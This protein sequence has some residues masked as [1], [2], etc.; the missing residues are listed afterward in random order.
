VGAWTA[1]GKDSAANVQL[2]TEITAYAI[3]DTS[4]SED[5][6]W[7][8]GT[9]VAGTF[10]DRFFIGAGAWVGSPT[11]T[12][13]GTGTFNA[14]TLYQNGS[15]L[16]SI[17]QP[18]SSDLTALAAGGGI[19]HTSGQVAFTDKIV[20][21]NLQQQIRVSVDFN[22]ANTDNAVAVG[23]PAGFS[24]YRI[25]GVAITG[26]SASLTTATF[27]L[28]TAASGGGVAAIA[29]GTA[30]TVSTASENTT[31]NMQFATPAN[32]NTAS[33]NAATLYF[34]VGTAQGS[35][36]TGNVTIFFQPVS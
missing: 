4:G 18:L 26:A 24:R 6:Q 29:G 27:G 21:P 30:I 12:D 8:F 32:V 20:A 36:A 35:P 10:A 11:G 17:Y 14:V 16:A 9:Y 31:N 23:L 3:D 13:K 25:G 33:Y 5:G 34:R 7:N 15:T 28:F 2:F 19:A 1:Q 22:S